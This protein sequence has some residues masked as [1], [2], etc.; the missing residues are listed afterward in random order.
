MVSEPC[1]TCGLSFYKLDA[2]LVSQL[3][4]VNHIIAP[5]GHFPRKAVG[6]KPTDHILRPPFLSARP[7]SGWSATPCSCHPMTA[8]R[9]ASSKGF[10]GWMQEMVSR[11]PGMGT[12]PQIS[13]DWDRPFLSGS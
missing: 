1:K 9:T 2:H 4:D 7:Y 3:S 12:F 11:R 8:L 5:P 13:A 10:A 6:Q